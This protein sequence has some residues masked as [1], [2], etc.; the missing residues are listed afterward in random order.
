MD[1]NT[2]AQQAIQQLRP[3]NLASIFIYLILI[4]SLVA[5]ALMPEKSVNSQYIMFVVVFFSIVDLLRGDGRSFPVP[6]FNDT[7]FATFLI[8]VGMFALPL[9]AGG[10]VR[11]TSRKGGAALPLC[12]LVGLIGGIYAVGSF[13]TPPTFYNTIF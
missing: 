3:D 11:R 1:I 12:L 8:H 2:L 5:V 10:M 4:L 6:G 7:G 13:I 9:I